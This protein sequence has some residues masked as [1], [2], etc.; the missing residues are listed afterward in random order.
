MTRSDSALHNVIVVGVSPTSGSPIALRWGAFEA[1]QRAA[2]LVAVRA[3]RAPRPPTAPGGR[4]SGITFDVEEQVALAESELQ[5]QVHDALGG[6][7]DVTCRLVRGSPLSVLVRQSAEADLLV[8]DAPPRIDFSQSRLAH[9]LV[10][11][12][13]CPVLI[14]PP[15]VTA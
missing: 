9:H 2:R 3:W 7:Q 14:M 5:S 8:I 4:P 15:A 6:E 1:T 13:R 12:A 10:Y 11:K